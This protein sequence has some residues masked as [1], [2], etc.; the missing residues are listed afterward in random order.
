MAPCILRRAIEQFTP[1][2]AKVDNVLSGEKIDA[3]GQFQIL[4]HEFQRNFIPNSVET[5]E[6][7]CLHD[8]P[9]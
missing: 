3:R 2:N 6:F 1:S 8:E 7:N 9:F 4:H 5:S